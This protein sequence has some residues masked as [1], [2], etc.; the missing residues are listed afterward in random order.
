MKSKL[1]MKDN[2]LR[3]LKGEMPESVPI[4]TMGIMENNGESPYKLVGPF[5]FDETRLT[6]C[7]EGR[8]DIWGVKLVTNE[9]TGFGCI[10]EPNN[11][12]LDD[13]T[14]WRDVIKAPEYPERIDWEYMVKKDEQVFGY[15]PA[16]N[17]RMCVIGIMPFQSL[18][19]FM[20]F[21]EGL[22]AMAE[23]PEECLALL[24]YMSDFYMPLVEAA[25]NYYHPDC[26]YL[27]D[28][29]ATKYN[30]FISVSMYREILKPIY[31][32]LTRPAVERGIPIQFH[33]CGRCEDFIDDML[34]FGVKILEPLQTENHLADIKKKYAG[35]LI[36]AGCYD[37][38]PPVDWPNVDEE[39]V[40]QDVRDVIDAFAPGGGFMATAGSIGQVGDE[41]MAKVNM[42]C[43]DELHKYCQDYYIR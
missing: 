16:K 39:K 38:N 15:D 7:P 14:K 10:P 4:H 31:T 23:E 3:L 20:G 41:V 37:W 12:I 24:D 27:L 33:N 18:M 6:P 43:A 17:A 28:D 21:N 9:E 5:L 36:M 1:T 32:K 26:M 42:W 22:I 29:T 35:R 34:D 30:P 13:I 11:F 40:R 8:T 2:F 25:V 19:E